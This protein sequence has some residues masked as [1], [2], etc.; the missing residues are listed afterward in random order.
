VSPGAVVRLLRVDDARE[1]AEVLRAERAFMAPWE[2]SRPGAYLTTC[3]GCRR[4][5]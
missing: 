3:I 4:A 2:P 1:L 5:R